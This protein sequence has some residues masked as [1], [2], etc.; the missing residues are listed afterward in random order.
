MIL[1]DFL[2][3]LKYFT[4]IFEPFLNFYSF[5]ANAFFK[6]NNSSDITLQISHIL[7]HWIIWDFEFVAIYSN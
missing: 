2:Q 5:Q 7:G 1:W 6:K 3:C 4:Y